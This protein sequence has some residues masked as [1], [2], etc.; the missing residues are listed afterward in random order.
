[1]ADQIR[2]HQMHFDPTAK[3]VWSGFGNDLNPVCGQREQIVVTSVAEA[4][5]C[6]KCLH[7]MERSST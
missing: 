1:M 7:I 2:K 6:L 5:D 3:G 4:V